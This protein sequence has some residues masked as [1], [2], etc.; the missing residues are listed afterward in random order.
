MQKVQQKKALKRREKKSKR[1]KKAGMI[2]GGGGAQYTKDNL[3]FVLEQVNQFLSNPNMS[4]YRSLWFTCANPWVDCKNCILYDLNA[5]GCLIG[6]VRRQVKSYETPA[7]GE[8]IPDI[9]E[10][11]SRIEFKLKNLK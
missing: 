7:L 9:L 1:P 10:I 5:R 2:L 8:T 6:R 3:N 4:T 11:K